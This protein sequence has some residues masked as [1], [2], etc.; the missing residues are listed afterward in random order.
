[1]KIQ[2]LSISPEATNEILPHLRKPRDTCDTLVHLEVFGVNLQELREKQT[3]SIRRQGRPVTLKLVDKPAPPV[4]DDDGEWTGKVASWFIEEGVEQGLVL[5][6]M[7][8]Q[9]LKETDRA[10]LF[11]REDNHRKVWV[12]K[13]VVEEVKIHD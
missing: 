11:R 2:R 4:L 10:V 12:P 6:P 1:M 9:I 5:D 13:S 3:M 8:G 7:P